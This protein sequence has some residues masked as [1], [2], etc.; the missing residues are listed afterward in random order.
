VSLFLSCSVLVLLLLLY[1]LRIRVCISLSFLTLCVSSVSHLLKT[2]LRELN[3]KHLVEGFGCRA[4][5]LVVAT[6]I[7]V[8]L[9]VT[10]EMLLSVA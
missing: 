10:M 3:R 7:S 4:R 8:C 9:V 2:V 6:G 1:S 5:R